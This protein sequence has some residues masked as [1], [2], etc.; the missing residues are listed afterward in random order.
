MYRRAFSIATAAWPPKAVSRVLILFDEGQTVAAVD[1]FDDADH[2]LF[3]LERKGQD[4]A[5]IVAGQAIGVGV[6]AGRV[7]HIIFDHRSGRA[8][9]PPDNAAAGRD[10]LA[11]QI[12]RDR[13][14][15]N[16]ED[17]FAGLLVHEEEGAGFAVQDVDSAVEDVL[18]QRLQVQGGGELTGHFVQ[19]GK[20]AR[21]LLRLLEQPRL[22]DRAGGLIGDGLQQVK[23]TARIG[24]TRVA[25]ANAQGADGFSAGIERH[26]H[27]GSH[28]FRAGNSV[29]HLTFTG[30]VL[31]QDRAAAADD[32]GRQA[33]PGRQGNVL[34]CRQAVV[35]LDGKGIIV[36]IVVFVV[37]R[38]VEVGSRNDLRHLGVDQLEHVIEGQRDVDALRDA[39]Q[40]VHLLDTA[41]EVDNR[42]HPLNGNGRLVGKI[43]E[44]GQIAR[45]VRL[46]REPRPQCQPAHGL[47]ASGQGDKEACTQQHDPGALRLQARR[48]GI[49]VQIQRQ[50]FPD[51]ILCQGAAAGES[52]VGAQPVILIGQRHVLV[53]ERIVGKDMD[54]AGGERGHDLLAQDPADRREIERTGQFMGEV[55]QA[56]DEGS[57]AAKERGIHIGL[58]ADANGV[59]DNRQGEDQAADPERIIGRHGHLED[60]AQAGDDEGVPANDEDGEQQVDDALSNPVVGAQQAEAQDGIAKRQ[61]VENDGQEKIGRELEQAQR[62]GQQPDGERTQRDHGPDED[63]A[64]LRLDHRRLRPIGVVEINQQVGEAGEAHI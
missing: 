14:S 22:D 33:G 34:A 42:L 29:V 43:L 51:E 7:L 49:A 38:N 56:L 60:Q 16:A 53:V 36:V 13:A 26:T 17:Q 20:L 31:R 58:Q 5:G 62:R 37:Q 3:H 15:R 47:I 18:K 52:N 19:G 48:Q 57:L 25:G 9:G 2:I 55:L 1:H 32:L 40:R 10:A 35:A 46:A 61:R 4:G 8:D 64:R 28:T 50:M 30:I 59:Q 41:L 12:L 63:H 21:P 23:L 45:R 11:E 27:P 24:G 54:P 44:K 39:R 6:P